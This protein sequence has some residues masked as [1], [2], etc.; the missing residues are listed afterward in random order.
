MPVSSATEQVG[1]RIGRYRILQQI[2][3]GGCGIVYMAEQQEPVKRRVALK[4]I[5][6]GMDTRQVLGRF[7]AERQ[8]LALMEH[9]NIAKILDAG[10]TELG[11]PFF[12]MELVRGIKITDYCDQNHL[13]TEQRL[14]LFIQICHA[15]QHAHQKGIIHR[16]IKP[17]NILVTLQEDGRPAPKIIDFGIAKAS[18]GQILTDKTVF[19]AFE[20]FI[21]TPAYMSPEQ[22]EM[23][24]V[25][26]DTRSDI[27]SL[28]VLL[29]ELLTGRTPFDSRRLIEAGLDGIR[30]IIREEEPPR[31]STRITTLAPDEQTTVAKRHHAEL[32]KLVHQVRGDL[33][34]IVMKCLEKDRTRRYE[35]A[36]GLARD[37][38]HHLHNEPVTAV[39]PSTAYKLAK[40]AR[41]HK[42]ALAVATII[43]GLL[44]AGIVVSSLLAVRARR[45]ELLQR[46]LANEAEKARKREATARAQ[47]V[48]A[49]EKEQEKSRQLAESLSQIEQQKLNENVTK[50]RP[51]R[52]L[53]FLAEALRRNPDN[54][55]AAY[56]LLSMLSYKDVAR[57]ISQKQFKGQI[58]DTHWSSLGA[59]VLTV[60]TNGALFLWDYR[61]ELP[62]AG[63]LKHAS[64]ILHVSFFENGQRIL[65]MLSDGTIEVW[66]TS[67]C[68]VPATLIHAEPGSTI[69]AYSQDGSRLATRK[70]P[71]P[72]DISASVQVWE[73]ASGKPL[74]KPVPFETGRFD[75]SMYFTADGKSLTIQDSQ[76]LTYGETSPSR[77]TLDIATGTLGPKATSSNTAY[78]YGD[79]YGSVG[80]P[81]ICFTGSGQEGLGISSV[82]GQRPL[83]FPL[84]YVNSFSQENPERHLAF[85]RHWNISPDGCELLA[86]VK[87][88][89]VL[90]SE[91]F[92]QT[93]P[94]LLDAAEATGNGTLGLWDVSPHSIL[95][96]T[97]LVPAKQLDY[98]GPR[99]NVEMLG[100]GSKLLIVD[101]ER[102]ARVVDAL[103]GKTLIAA[104]GKL[105]TVALA[106]AAPDAQTIVT[107]DTNGVVRRWR[108]GDGEPASTELLDPAQSQTN[109]DVLES[110]VVSRDGGRLAVLWGSGA[111]GVWDAKN[112]K[113]LA[114]ISAPVA[115]R[116]DDS[117]SE[118]ATSPNL[119]LSADGEKLALTA[120]DN[121]VRVY[122][123][124]TG[125][126][127]TGA[128]Q[129]PKEIIFVRFSPDG[130]KLATG[131]K[132]DSVRIWNVPGGQT[133]VEPLRHDAEITFLGFQTNGSLV[134]FSRDHTVRFWDSQTGKMLRSFKPETEGAYNGSGAA[135]IQLSE[136]GRLLVTL[137]SDNSLRIWDTA[138]ATPLSEP[139]GSA[140][141]GYASP[142]GHLLLSRNVERVVVVSDAGT[143]VWELPLLSGPAPEWLPR[144]AEA[145]AG[146]RITSQGLTEPVAPEGL[147]ALHE[148]VL[149]LGGDD[150]YTRWARWFFGA[151]QALTISPRS[152]ATVQD[153]ISEC[154]GRNDSESLREALLLESSNL[155]ALAAYLKIA[156]H[157]LAN[158]DAPQLV[159]PGM[160]EEEAK[161]MQ[162]SAAKA[163]AVTARA[164]A[165]Q[166]LGSAPDSSIAWYVKA[167]ALH[168][169]DQFEQALAALSRVGPADFGAEFWC[170]KGRILEGL[171]RTN[172]ADE[173][174]A[175]G[176]ESCNT[177]STARAWAYLQRSAF[178][179]RQNRLTEATRE[180]CLAKGI[181]LRA[182]DTKANLIDLSSVYA[183]SLSR[184]EFLQGGDDPLSEL[185][186]GVQ[187]LAGTDFDV[188][189]IV[190]R[191]EQTYGHRPYNRIKPITIPVNLHCR[192]LHF[193]QSAAYASYQDQD[194]MSA[195][196]YIVHYVD[197][198]TREI[199][200]LMGKHLLDWFYYHSQPVAATQ[201][202]IVW[203]GLNERAQKSQVF[204]RLFSMIWTNPS[205]DLEI[206]SIDAEFGN[207]S[208]SMLKPFLIALTADT[209][210]LSPA[211]VS[212]PEVMSQSLATLGAA[213]QRRP[214]A[215]G[216][217]RA[218]AA[219]LERLNRADEAVGC[220]SNMIAFAQANPAGTNSLSAL[221]LGRSALLR[222]LNRPAEAQADWL[223]AMGVP[224]RDPQTSSNLLDL[225]LF[226]NASLT[227]DW[228]R[229]FPPAP[230]GEW[231]LTSLPQ[232]VQTFAG[233][234]FDVRGVIQLAGRSKRN[235]TSSFPVSV[236]AISAGQACHQLHFLHGT[237]G[238]V[239]DGVPIG[240]YVIHFAGGEQLEVPINYGE[241]VR[242]WRAQ[243]SSKEPTARAA[244]VW[245]GSNPAAQ[246]RGKELRL[247]EFIWDNSRTGSA[248]E[249]I[250]FISSQTNSAPF[251]IAI[252]A[253]P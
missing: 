207:A 93:D 244:I 113:R 71:R 123:A 132:D 250:D 173:A 63:P 141:G 17:S 28:G 26:I 233:T 83:L 136:D 119:A 69:A 65:V 114:K 178:L 215:F 197:Q 231:L 73:L 81:D 95:P 186:V 10:A 75:G 86:E 189:G 138:T 45:A 40:L 49:R 227:S 64:H 120:A 25:D 88:T 32:P 91:T 115:A 7:E 22:A 66:N 229:V 121:T 171:L 146:I 80:A 194:G 170:L 18:A 205:P 44:V 97:V 4:V 223:R 249:T 128:F 243:P 13:S 96:V 36:N 6:P 27:Y 35:T 51:G 19:T 68:T 70:Q 238:R 220:Y 85:V 167:K 193:L 251:L 236:A 37:V 33:D 158:P 188:R 208:F 213:A 125:A 111:A 204:I 94:R 224:A 29:Y 157:N 98:Y 92:D 140:E 232:G 175:A 135:Q 184:V 248:I 180:Y 106:Q 99:G 110:L 38:E 252:T 166:L 161:R 11:R 55:R 107:A 144:L 228:T 182:P 219:L 165:E 245:A 3:E 117:D 143:R 230:P 235:L 225:S 209:E 124:A 9:P 206:K 240:R 174:F 202:P 152:P 82:Y 181:P 5:K 226:F 47:E 183:S 77:R 21:G 23:M 195:G 39:A 179:K 156:S 191:L 48:T 79:Y 145:L 190:C 103:T 216:F 87:E 187:N 200:I 12:V 104:L 242:D 211:A 169:L 164:Q 185:P 210:T 43:T 116:F 222:R 134:T 41:R 241:N 46:Q 247:C 214:E 149:G 177:N 147:N 221:L 218:K 168:Q 154:I 198:Q 34:W 246:G 201:A 78:A 31:P 90:G 54:Y 130:L 217:G 100:D 84:G 2:G 153:H 118:G 1:D 129:H 127:L 196:K 137:D 155:R 139:I 239:A 76:V 62:L 212:E 58:L 192:A 150:I 61:K 15:V 16:D 203:A 162:R 148:T 109:N 163:A 74:T 56:R 199:P 133:A 72:E 14:A 253:E 159:Y 131:C 151:R 57:P 50:A 122:E 42:A 142:S 101:S 67:N 126:P 30:R 108:L 102:T 160:S 89:S 234:Q 60:T 176:I 52:A 59:L 8:A 172:E 112:A 237:D 53:A 24:A 20:Q 105:G